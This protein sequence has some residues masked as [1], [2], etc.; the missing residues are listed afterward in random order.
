MEIQTIH[1][2]L[3]DV[4]GEKYVTKEKFLTMAYS[5]DFGSEAARWP[6]LVVWPGST[7][8]VAEVFKIANEFRIPVSARGGGGTC[9]ASPRVTLE[10]SAYRRQQA[11]DAGAE[12]IVSSCPNCYT[13]FVRQP[14]VTKSILRSKRL[15]RSSM[16]PCSR[17]STQDTYDSHQGITV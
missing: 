16:L 4:L 9:V 1:D 2:R 11:L 8:V 5:Q 6:A 13:R 14:A 15:P 3:V 12:Q 10:T 7:E 17:F